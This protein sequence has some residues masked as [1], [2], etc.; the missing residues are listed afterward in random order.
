MIKNEITAQIKA[1]YKHYFGTEKTYYH[2]DNDEMPHEFPRK[3]QVGVWEADEQFLITSFATVGMSRSP[4]RDG[5]RAE[6][7]F[8][9]RAT[10]SEEQQHE[11]ALFL[12]NLALYPFQAKEPL[13][14]W[15]TIEDAGKIPLFTAAQSIL[16]H[17]AFI[18][19][20]WNYLSSSKEEV[21]ILN[22]VPI[23][24]EECSL[25][26]VDEI[27]NSLEQYDIFLPR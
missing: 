1:E 2:F 3:I 21:K 9:I 25:G 7:H 16:L 17:P 18:E 8:A 12:A 11:V 27:L 19:N 24:Q 23:T 20:G 15:Y 13:D 14:W 22:V 10:L 26:S 5:S 4:M 6:L